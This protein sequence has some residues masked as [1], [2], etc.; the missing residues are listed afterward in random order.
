MK[1]YALSILFLFIITLVSCNGAG[2]NV[3]QAGNGDMKKDTVAVAERSVATGNAAVVDLVFK[4]EFPLDSVGSNSPVMNVDIVLPVASGGTAI[5]HSINREIVYAALDCYADTPEDAV[6]MFVNSRLAEY[7]DNYPQYVNVKEIDGSHNRLN[8]NYDIK[9]RLVSDHGGRLCFRI[10]RIT[11]EGG[12]HG[13]EST[14]YLTFDSRSGKLITLDD[15]FTDDYS[16]TL[17]DILV[18][19]LARKLGVEG[20][21]EVKSLGYLYDMDMYPTSN[22]RLDND[23]ILFYYNSYEIA[24]YALGHTRIVIGYNELKD[25]LK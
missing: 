10:D 18:A 13:L 16:G 1:K 11:Y 23:S 12:A 17:C 5:A 14:Y 8:F 20:I 24:P 9:G 4:K 22:F 6:A 25:I 7:N 15:I 2:T 21:D 3:E 19:A